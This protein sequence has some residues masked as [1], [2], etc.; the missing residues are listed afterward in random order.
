MRCGGEGISLLL[1]ELLDLQ[2]FTIS[3][4]GT[5]EVSFVENYNM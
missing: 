3:R 4:S 2:L 1:E 5:F